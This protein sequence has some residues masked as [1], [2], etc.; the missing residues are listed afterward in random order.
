MPSWRKLPRRLNKRPAGTSGPLLFP[1]SATS[2]EELRRTS[3]RLAEW[4]EARA[5]GITPWDL[6]YTLARRRAHRPVR[7]SVTANSLTEL[8]DGLREVAES[9]TPYVAALGKDDR[10][11]VWVFSGQGSQWAAMGAGLLSS[12]PVFAATVAQAEPLIAREAGFSVTEAMTTP[13]TLTGITRI[14]PTLFTMQVALAAAM[15]SYGVRPGAVIGHSLGEVAAAVVAGALSLDDGVRVICRRSHLLAR[16]AGVGAMASVELPASRVRE[17]LGARG[18]TDVVVSVVASPQSTVIGGATHTVRDLVAAW[19]ARDVPA[20]E[21]AVD[22]ASHSPQVDPILTELADALAEL[23]P[24]T[25]TIPVYSATMDDPRGKPAWDARYW[26]DNLRQPVEFAKAVQAALE[27]GHRIFAELAPHPLL[28]RAVEQSAEAVDMPVQ[29]L[30]SLRRDQTMPHGLLNFVADLHATG[31]AVDF[32]VLYPAGRLVDAPL[33]TWT[34]SRLILQPDDRIH[35]A[36]GHTS[37][38]VH[39][40]LG[41]HVHL[42]E[43]PE[44]HVWQGD[45]GIGA[46]PWLGDHRIHD[47]AVLPGAAYCEMALTAARTLLGEASEVRDLRF[48]QMLLLDEETP[49]SAVATFDA[50]DVAEFLVQTVQSG[51]RTRRAVAVL[52]RAEDEQE[53]PR[54]DISAL[55]AAQCDRVDGTE[56]RNALDARGIQSG[57]AFAGLAAASTGAGEVSYVLAE[58]GLPAPIRSQHAAYGVHPALLDA[59]FQSIGAHP[60]ASDAAGGGLLLPLGARLVRGYGSARDARYCITRVRPDKGAEVT[61]DLD[62]LDE[63]GKVL[64]IVRGL[65]MGTGSSEGSER[66]RVLAE[67][68]L[69]VDWQPQALPELPG[70]D[71]GVWLLIT[72]AETDGLLA[73]RLA[74]S[75]KSHGAQCTTMSWHEE[76][77]HQAAAERLDTHLRAGG[78]AGVVIVTPSPTGEPDE[79]TLH[80]GR[81]HVRHLVRIASQLAGFSGEPP[82]LYLMTNRAQA[83]LPHDHLNLDQAG[84]RGLMRVIGSEQPQLRPTQI[85]I[86]GDHEIEHLAREL[87]SA[88]DADE[89]AWRDGQWYIARLQPSPL[90]PEDRRTTTQPIGTTGYAWRFEPRVTWKRWKWLPLRVFH[91]D[92]DRSRSR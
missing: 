69:T 13:A 28:T 45:V 70:T 42:P 74:D 36:D 15:Q 54:V 91:R 89:T 67:R 5:D 60:A 52:S 47:V 66:D 17:E 83:V 33:P 8:G 19:E 16:L 32:A 88:S 12:E 49:I 92:R 3:R 14:Q 25:P 80:R 31:A 9:T 46:L 50:P 29:T 30:A 76:A 20:H 81:E 79:Q 10:G 62:V 7:T 84:L 21:V 35:Q 22:V 44:R 24:M 90:R 4:V 6:A 75:L 77:D 65:R 61:A 64:L 38:S 37:V 63:T 56:L 40:L 1:L 82:R 78:I 72:L 39:P 85:D 59:C 58:V 11:P 41:S 2:A 53:P 68:L 73:S 43:E 23:T 55:L 57:P 34:R 18:V 26:V 87:L 48:E 51:E 86:D 71:A 27:D